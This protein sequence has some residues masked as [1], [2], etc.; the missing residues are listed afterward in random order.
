MIKSA[1]SSFP[2]LHKTGA[3][4]QTY[5]I[6][7]SARCAKIQLCY[8]ELLGSFNTASAVASAIP[9]LPSQ[10]R[11]EMATVPLKRNMSIAVKAH[12]SWVSGSVIKQPGGEPEDRSRPGSPRFGSAVC[13]G[14]CGTRISVNLALTLSCPYDGIPFKRVR[15]LLYSTGTGDGTPIEGMRRVYAARVP[16]L[17]GSSIAIR[18]TRYGRMQAI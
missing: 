3:S 15:T 4:R 10:R 7:Q 17:C 16:G 1:V 9:F 8:S 6:V 5:Q 13:Y 12:P 2:R 14:M 11:T 18:A